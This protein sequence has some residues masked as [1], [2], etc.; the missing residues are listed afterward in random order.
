MDIVAEAKY[1]TV[2]P[3]QV[4]PVAQ[5]VNKLSPAIAIAHLAV[6]SRRAAKPVAAVL[7]SAVANA[8]K[9][10]KLSEDSLRIKLIVVDGGPALKRWRPVSRGRAHAY[11]KRMSHIRVVLTDEG[12]SKSESD[13]KGKE[14]READGTKS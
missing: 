10:A 7:K 6:M 11:K 8:T 9:N 4:R 13:I 2:S 12:L 14:I 5:A 3:R 1:T